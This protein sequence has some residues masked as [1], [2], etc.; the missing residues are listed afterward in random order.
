MKIYLDNTATTPL[1]KEVIR[2]MKETMDNCFGNPSSIHQFGQYA[3]VIVENARKQIAKYLNASPSEIFFTSG[4][5]EANNTVINTAVRDLGVKHIISSPI[6][7]P[8][9]LNTIKA[10]AERKE[11]SYSLVELNSKGQIYLKSLEKELSEH[12]NALVSLMHANNEIATLLPIKEVSKLCR[13]YK[14]LFHSDTVQTMAHYKIDMEAIDLDFASCSAHKFHGPKGVGFMY[15]KSKNQ[16]KIKSFIK[17]GGQERNMRAGTE[18]IYG[19]KGLEKAFV[20][21][22]EN[23]NEDAKKIKQLR[24]YMASR[25]ETAIPNCRFAGTSKDRGLYTILNVLLPTKLS[26]E[27]LLIKLDMN[28]IAASGGSACASGVNNGSHVLKH[29]LPD[30]KNVSV[31]FSFSK[32]N[33]TEEIDF[34]V[35]KLVEIVGN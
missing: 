14:A 18:N 30:E 3:K 11:I 23:M 5:T 24:D 33:T 34:T 31:R 27:I 20:L 28:G 15:I 16:S 17:G 9:V 13:N 32:L 19:I 25:L 4:G 7:H 21:A 35:N 8:S 22:N 29:I 12:K 2:A 6:E 1:D 10:L 26:N